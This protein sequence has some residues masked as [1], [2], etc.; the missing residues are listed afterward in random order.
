MDAK[1]VNF[2]MHITHVILGV[3]TEWHIQIL[4]L[5]AAVSFLSSVMFRF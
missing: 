3:L 2:G 1:L 5:L 4:L